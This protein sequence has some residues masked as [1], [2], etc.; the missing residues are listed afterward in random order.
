MLKCKWRQIN[1]PWFYTVAATHKSW[2]KSDHGTERDSW[3]EAFEGSERLYR[4]KAPWL[5]QFTLPEKIL[6][7]YFFCL[8]YFERKKKWRKITKGNKRLA[9]GWFHTPTSF[10]SHPKGL[11][12]C[13]WAR[14]SGC[15]RV[16]WC[17]PKVCKAKRQL[18][19]KAGG[20]KIQRN[21]G[22]PEVFRTAQWCVAN[23]STR[24]SWENSPFG[25]W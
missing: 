7:N 16:P 13:G 12:L 6:A 23:I 14:C 24:G 5:L 18:T 19:F 9:C 11:T 2:R 20:G 21:L 15:K 17:S 22:L 4:A 3:T 25:L 1:S 8:M 10:R